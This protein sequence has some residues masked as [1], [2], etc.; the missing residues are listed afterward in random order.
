MNDK[1]TEEFLDLDSNNGC[2]TDDDKPFVTIEEV[3]EA[4]RA[5]VRRKNVTVDLANF[6]KHLFYNLT[7]LWNELN[8]KTYQIS[9]SHV[10]VVEKPVK[11]EVF[12]A[13]LRDR[14]VHHI[15]IKKVCRIFEERCFIDNSFA[16]RK[17]KGTHFGGR[18]LKEALVNVTENFTKDKVVC[19]FDI[20]AFFMSI[21]K[22][23]LWEL[24]EYVF[25]KYYKEF[26]I[27]ERDLGFLLYYFKL[28]IENNPQDGCIF[29][30][31][32]SRWE[33]L[34]QTKSMLYNDRKHGMPI[35]NLTSQ[36]LA[37]LY[38]SSFDHF[39]MKN[40]KIRFY[41]RYVDDFVFICDTTEDAIKLREIIKTYLKDRLGLTLHPNKVY[42][43]PANRG[44]KFV[45]IFHKKDHSSVIKRTKGNAFS[46]LHAHTEDA[47][48]HNAIR[49]SDVLAVCNTLNSYLGSFKLWNSY[50]V[51]KKL[52]TCEDFKIW[53]PFFEVAEDYSKIKLTPLYKKIMVNRY[54]ILYRLNGTLYDG[55]L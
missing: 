40:E 46:A 18:K 33:G 1:Q 28:V 48:K 2:F 5:T 26:G 6:E 29:C 39:I 23:K 32:K 34:P 53:K 41:G 17:G 9:N 27:T 13:V 30:C 12:A 19:V 7:I 51:R 11:R 25:R 36:F 31:P 20:R 43:Q 24:T 14:I 8:T 38:L 55:T 47:K 35:G 10:F 3:C 52:L 44:C 45:G 4:Y 54:D 37:N 49:Y 22:S 15:L 21:D 42:I 16:C 50:K